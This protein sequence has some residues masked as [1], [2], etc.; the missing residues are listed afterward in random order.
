MLNTNLGLA[1]VLIVFV[2]DG[3]VGAWVGLLLHDLRLG[4]LVLVGLLI[5]HVLVGLVV[6]VRILS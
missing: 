2:V 1:A 5:A 6:S 4:L 3:L